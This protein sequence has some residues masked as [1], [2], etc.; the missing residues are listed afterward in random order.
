MVPEFRRL[1]AAR[2]LQELQSAGCGLAEG[3]EHGADIGT[4]HIGCP[5]P[6]Q[7]FGN[8][9]HGRDVPICVCRNQGA[10]NVTRQRFLQRGEA[11]AFRFALFQELLGFVEPA[12]Q[13]RWQERR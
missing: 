4:R 3:R 11:V 5:A 1:N 12:N 13:R 8:L 6:D 7:L 10:A 2:R 9:V